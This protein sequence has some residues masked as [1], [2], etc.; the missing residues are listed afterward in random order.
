MIRALQRGDLQAASELVVRSWARTYVDLIA[1]DQQP[2]AAQQ[3]EHLSEPDSAGWVFDL[4]GQVAAVALVTGLSDD[5][6]ELS[7]LHVDP[8][9]QGAGVG[10]QLHD[11]VLAELAVAGHVRIHLWVFEQNEHARAFYAARGWSEDRGA[12]DVPD[13]CAIAPAVRIAREL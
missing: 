9:A 4:S 12:A 1:P 5:D 2:T 13:R 11:H 8:P 6:P 3:A 7:V 10:S